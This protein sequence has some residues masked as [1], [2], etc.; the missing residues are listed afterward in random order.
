MMPVKVCRCC[1]VKKMLSEFYKRP[2]T[3]DGRLGKCIPCHRDYVAK[4]KL[5][6]PDRR[7]AYDQTYKDRHAERIQ[8]MQREWVE[9]NRHKTRSY[10]AKVRAA[11]L[12]ATPPWVLNDP[13]MLADI[14][15]I[16]RHARALELETGIE[17]H[18]DHIEP[19]K[20]EDRCGL[21]VPWNLRPLS[22]RENIAKA[23]RPAVIS[24]PP[25]QPLSV[26]SADRLASFFIVESARELSP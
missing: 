4:F 6:H 5:K 22:R 14:Q 25:G 19:L 13:K 3:R 23:N 9:A 20:G 21:H 1:G 12:N 10:H 7:K 26:S 2:D 18:V 11:M 24:A 15:E 17:Y 16:Y 8:V